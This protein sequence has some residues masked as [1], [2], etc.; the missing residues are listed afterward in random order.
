MDSRTGKE[1]RTVRVRVS[2]SAPLSPPMSSASLRRTST[3]RRRGGVRVENVR[4]YAASGLALL[5]RPPGRLASRPPRDAESTPPRDVDSAS[6]LLALQRWRI[7][8]EAN[9][10]DLNS[11][12][13]AFQRAR[14]R[15]NPR[16]WRRLSRLHSWPSSAN[17]T[18]NELG[19]KYKPLPAP[20]RRLIDLD[21]SLPDRCFSTKADGCV[22]RRGREASVPPAS[23]DDAEWH[24]RCH[25]IASSSHARSAR[26]LFTTADS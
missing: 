8:K 9:E 12:K 23:N 22:P 5:P 14:N 2:E 15:P 10:T 6:L 13:R 17:Q 7:E 20:W 1:N 16:H 3:C 21:P 19:L 18:P 24:S 4:D 26:S 11:L 25:S